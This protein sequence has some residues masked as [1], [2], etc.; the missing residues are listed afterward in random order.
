MCRFQLNNERE[1]LMKV[2]EDDIRGF[3][4]SVTLELNLSNSRTHS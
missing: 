1:S 3:I 2:L 4:H